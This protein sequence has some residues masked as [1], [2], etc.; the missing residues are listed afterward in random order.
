MA[1]RVSDTP[2]DLMLEAL[3]KEIMK[4]FRIYDGSNRLITQYEAFANTLDTQPCIKTEYTYIGA[5]T[6]I[7]KMK[8]SV[9]VWSSAYDI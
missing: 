4:A 2:G 3:G 6:Q 1:E 5:T 8:E 9:S 7:E